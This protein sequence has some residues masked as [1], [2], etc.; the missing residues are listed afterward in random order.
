MKQT[1]KQG[2]FFARPDLSP[3]AYDFGAIPHHKKQHQGRG[4]CPHWAANRKNPHVSKVSVSLPG[5]NRLADAP[6]TK[7]NMSGN[8]WMTSMVNI[9]GKYS[10]PI[11]SAKLQ[12]GLQKRNRSPGSRHHFSHHPFLFLS[13]QG[14]KTSTQ[15]R[16]GLSENKL[17]RLDAALTK[18]R[19]IGSAFLCHLS[20]S[21]TCLPD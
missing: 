7:T 10:G 20:S 8:E 17:I 13:S 18:K 21:K 6:E 5:K 12:L 9:I 16:M 3:M 1:S 11:S 19:T 14:F 4:L 15:F 2:I